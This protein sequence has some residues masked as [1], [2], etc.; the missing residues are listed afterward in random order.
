[1]KYEFDNV[2]DRRGTGSHKWDRNL[3]FFGN[4]DVIPMWVA[5]MDFPCPEPVVRAIQERAKHPIYGYSFPT[6]SLYDAIIDRLYRY[7]GWRIKREWIVFTSGVVDGF[8]TAVESLTRP[9]DEVIIQPPVYYPFAQCIRLAGVTVVKNPLRF[10]GKR[11]E[12]DYEGLA[13]LF[14]VQTTFP[15]K[16]PRIK[17]LLLC[18]PHNPVGRVWSTTEL[19][20]MAD[21]CVKNECVIISDEIHC[22]LLLGDAKHTVTATLS[23]EIEQ[24][25]ITFMAASKTFNLAG[26]QTGF[27]VVPNNRL[28]RALI[29][30]RARR[31]SGNLFGY[32]ALE[33]AFRYGDEYLK[34][35]REY[36]TGNVRFMSDFI[37]ERIPELKVIEPEGTYLVWVDFRALGMDHIQLQKFIRFKAG[38][39]LDDGYLFGEEGAGF[40][41]FNVACPRSVLEEALYRLEKAVKGFLPGEV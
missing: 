12:M 20:K 34:Q 6:E 23:P 8:Y 7:Y 11:Y 41:R 39:A 37:K 36:L 14:E 17:A 38:L 33:A 18:S 25:T 29:E 5:D 31:G 15:Q 2:V 40:E 28:R 35:L 13:S 27:A 30:T 22:D 9:G 4:E 26:L 19:A 16:M 24:N 21:I 10:I 32:V 3:E 1:M